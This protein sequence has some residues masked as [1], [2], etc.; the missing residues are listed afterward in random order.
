M[1]LEKIKDWEEAVG[2]IKGKLEWKCS[3][4]REER[5]SSMKEWTN[6]SNDP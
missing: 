3:R 2:E 6:M 4:N 1:R 5:L